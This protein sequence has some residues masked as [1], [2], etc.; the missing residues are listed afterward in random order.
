MKKIFLAL[1]LFSTLLF[2]GCVEET[3]FEYSEPQLTTTQPTQI[4]KEVN[5]LTKEN[6]ELKQEIYDLNKTLSHYRGE[7]LAL[8]E[9]LRK[10]SDFNQTGG[11]EA[12]ARL[13]APAVSQRVELEGFTRKVVTEGVLLTIT[14][15]VNPGKGRVLVVTKPLMGTIFQDAANTAVMVAEQKTGV[16]L[17]GS[18]VIFSVNGTDVPGVEGPSAGALMTSILISALEDKPVNQSVTITGTISLNGK[19]GAIGGVVEKSWAAKETG[20]KLVLI[21]KENSVLVD[22]VEVKEKHGSWT[23]VRRKPEY[24]DAEEYIEENI[25]IEVEYVEDIDEALVF[26]Q[27]S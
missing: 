26:I 13:D 5:Q 27:A 2:A 24:V 22:W 20:K 3:Q 9:E 25:G 11:V 12:F 18:D 15:E 6:S 7:V 14:V 4:E 21:P 8:Q 10:H 23:I 19:V 1:L 17:S 16:D